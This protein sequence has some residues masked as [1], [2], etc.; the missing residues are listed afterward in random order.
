M[1]IVILRMNNKYTFEITFFVFLYFLKIYKNV[2]TKP[3]K[4]FVGS[5]LY[6]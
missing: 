1:I 3:G 2:L 6:S 4:M 5:K